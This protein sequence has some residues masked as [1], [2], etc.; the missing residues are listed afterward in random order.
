MNKNNK[1]KINE[2]KNPEKRLE[3]KNVEKYLKLSP[4]PF[5]GI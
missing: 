4:L 2:I 5:P 3:N 1:D